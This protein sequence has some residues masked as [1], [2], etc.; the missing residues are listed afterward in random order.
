MK[1]HIF[2]IY[3]AKALAYLPP[4]VLPEI[5][6]AL[7]VFSDMVNSPEHQFGKHPED[8]NLYE[9]GM[10]HDHNA[11]IETMTPHSHGIGTAYLKTKTSETLELF[12]EKH[13]QTAPQGAGAPSEPASGTTKNKKNTT[14]ENGEQPLVRLSQ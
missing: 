3:D 12:D 14:S 1:Y 4:F 9:I 5:G 13:T 11:Q 2:A 10:Y 6:M 8:Y 7:R